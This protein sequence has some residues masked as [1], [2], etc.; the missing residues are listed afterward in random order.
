M[1]KYQCWAPYDKVVPTQVVEAESSFKARQAYAD[2]HHKQVCEVV[3]RRQN[4]PT[5]RRIA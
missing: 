3:A 1:S 5:E 4:L 2:R